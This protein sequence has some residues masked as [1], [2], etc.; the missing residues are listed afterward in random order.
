MKTAFTC[1]ALVASALLLSACGTAN[2]QAMSPIVN[3]IA[4]E[5]PHCHVSGSFNAGAGGLRQGCVTGAVR[6]SRR[7]CQSR[8]T[9]GWLPC[10]YPFKAGVR[11]QLGSAQQG[12]RQ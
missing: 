2:T 10:V 1:A 3:A 7:A 4:A 6:P 12:W 9:G 11:V 8:P 5:I